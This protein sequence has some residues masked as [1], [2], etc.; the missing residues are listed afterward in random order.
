MSTRLYV[1]Q[2]W[3]E[4][5]G[6]WLGAP[7]K[8]FTSKDEATEAAAELARKWPKRRWAVHRL[9]VG[10]IVTAIVPVKAVRT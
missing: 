4:R 1:V 9:D 7:G 5:H 2:K 6:K 10:P 8:V 3:S